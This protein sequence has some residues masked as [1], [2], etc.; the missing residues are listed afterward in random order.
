[1]ARHAAS[2]AVAGVPRPRD[3]LA[4]FPRNGAQRPLAA[5]T[6][7]VTGK[8]ASGGQGGAGASPGP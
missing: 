7:A 2:M 8:A 3:V 1:M 5:R 6:T 4:Q